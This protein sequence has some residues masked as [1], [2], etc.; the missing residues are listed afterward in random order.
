MTPI[1]IH[2]N[3]TK[4]EIL[5]EIEDGGLGA[6]NNDKSVVSII[7]GKEASIPK[8]KS[9]VIIMIYEEFPSSQ[10]SYQTEVTAMLMKYVDTRYDSSTR[11]SSTI[12]LFLSN[13]DLDVGSMAALQQSRLWRDIAVYKFSMMDETTLRELISSLFIQA[14]KIFRAKYFL[15]FNTADID[16]ID[17]EISFSDIFLVHMQN[18]I[19]RVHRF[20]DAIAFWC[21][22][23]CT[24][25]GSF[26]IR[27]V[28]VVYSD[29]HV[30]ANMGCNETGSSLSIAFAL[31]SD[32]YVPIL[33]RSNLPQ[34]FIVLYEIHV[35]SSFVVQNNTLPLSIPLVIYYFFK[36]I[37][38]PV[39]V[40][41]TSLSS[42]DVFS[43]VIQE[44]SRVL[45]HEIVQL[46]FD[47]KEWK[48]KRSLADHPSVK[49]IRDE[50]VREQSKR[51]TTYF[52]VELHMVGKTKTEMSSAEY[53]IRDLI[54][55]LPLLTTFST[56]RSTLMKN[57]IL[58]MLSLRYVFDIRNAYP[59]Y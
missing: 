21:L 55:E 7:L 32:M 40:Y 18:D 50:I 48:V 33:E 54:E 1:F 31:V 16:D 19:R 26:S 49:N 59:I 30:I 53:N 52:V 39:V 38:V 23:T 27:K 13:Y 3:K 34:D 9:T 46:F 42:S 11:H 28:S 14:A 25:A 47:L 44:S 22:S 29:Q 20:I 41:I 36:Q 58:F 4:E 56:E 24:S 5:Q 12:S 8:R 45:N 37:Y 17:F 35:E 51:P 2:L 10:H 6:G 57:R 15:K 43:R